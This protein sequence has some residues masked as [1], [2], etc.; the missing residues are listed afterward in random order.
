MNATLPTED[1]KCDKQGSEETVE[2]AH[3]RREGWNKT[4]EV[5]AFALGR[6]RA[7]GGG[8]RGPGFVRPVRP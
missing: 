5:T 3:V 6:G 8:G 1:A 7:W 2:R 4:E